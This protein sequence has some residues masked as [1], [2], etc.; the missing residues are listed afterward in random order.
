ME[1][2]SAVCQMT[3]STTNTMFWNMVATDNYYKCDTSETCGASAAA[4]LNPLPNKISTDL[5][6]TD[7]TAPV[8]DNDPYAPYCKPYTSAEIAANSYLSQ[9]AC[10]EI[11]CIYQRP[12]VTKDPQDFQFYKV[13]AV[14]KTTDT[15]IIPRQRSNVSVG[16]SST[17]PNVVFGA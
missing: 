5:L 9:F 11:T 2:D 7:W 6:K 8:L 10:K 17:S 15:M 1:A 4:V 13:S 3:R 14:K 12:L 16:F